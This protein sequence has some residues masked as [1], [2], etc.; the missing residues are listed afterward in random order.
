VFQ[1]SDLYPPL[2]GFYDYG[3][4]GVELKNNIKSL[5]WRKMVHQRGD[6]YGIDAAIVSSSKVWDASGHVSG[7]SDPMVDCKE[8]KV[9][10]RADQGSAAFF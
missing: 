1:S 9:R 2:G 4:L 3:P 6:I 7:F 8:T 10:Y 5:W